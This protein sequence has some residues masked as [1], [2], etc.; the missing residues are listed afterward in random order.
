[1]TKTWHDQLRSKNREEL[2]EV[3]KKLFLV[4]GFVNVSIKD[5]CALAGVSR[6]TFYKH[7]QSLDEL[8]FEV[9]MDILQHMTHYLKNTD[10]PESTGRAR[11]Q[12]MLEAWVDFGRL[13][14]EHLRFILLFDLHFHAYETNKELKERY[15]QFIHSQ[16][17]EHFLNAALEAGIEDGS[18]KEELNVLETG[19]F[20]F[21]TMMGLLHKLSLTPVTDD[22]DELLH[23]TTFGDRFIALIIQSL[24]RA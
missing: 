5:V 3:G 1:M 2:L 15:E 9:Q 16:K 7:F 17:E 20:I 21:T 23:Y 4:K 19:H 13:Y 6:V 10:T 22:G 12:A 18:L 14:A 24:S 11:L 8:I